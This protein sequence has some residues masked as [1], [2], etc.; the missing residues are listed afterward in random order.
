MGLGL[1]LLL[2]GYLVVPLWSARQAYYSEYAE[3]SAGTGQQSD[4]V[5]D[6]VILEKNGFTV[7]Y[8]E[9]T[10]A[11]TSQSANSGKTKEGKKNN[12]DDSDSSS[13][14]WFNI[15]NLLL[16][17]QGKFVSDDDEVT[18]YQQ[19]VYG[20]LLERYLPLGS[21]KPCWSQNFH[22]GNVVIWQRPVLS[23]QAIRYLDNGEFLLKV[24]CGLLIG[25]LTVSLFIC[26]A[27][28]CISA[29]QRESTTT[30]DSKAIQ[31]DELKQIV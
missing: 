23:A 13:F 5:I 20:S 8:R 19:T 21:T 18:T 6:N 7:Y 17:L 2:V 3:L 24:Y 10:M 4:C 30:G 29:M 12:H 14:S 31:M 11:S 28:T 26:M 15:N 22:S 27:S 16:M 25:L 1:S 9:A